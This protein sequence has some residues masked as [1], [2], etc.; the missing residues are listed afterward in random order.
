[1]IARIFFTT[2]ACCLLATF[3]SVAKTLELKFN[4]DGKFKIVQFTD[5]H[6]KYGNFASD[7]AIERINQVLDEERPDLV[8]FTGDIIYAAPADKGM[9]QILQLVANRKLPFIV[10]F[11]NHDDEFGMNRHQLY[12]L[13]RTISGNL[14]TDQ[15]TADN[16]DVA[17]HIKSSNSK[18][19]AAV[20]YCMDSRTY[21]TLKDVKGY[22]WFSFDQIEW[23]R[24]QSAS[25]TATNNETPLPALAFFHIPLPEFNLAATDENAVMIGTRMEQA[26]APVVNTGMFA[27]MKEC[28]D[29]MGVFVG[30][31]HD[32]DYAVMWQ[33]IL[34]GYGRYTGG[35]TVYNNLSNGARVIVLN[36]GERTFSS[37]IR[38]NDGVVNNITYPDSFVRA[39]H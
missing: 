28:G 3:C 36:E 24:K 29:V 15:T 20:I 5:V 7:I 17:L 18:Q 16:P 22:G 9:I 37:W 27:A 1:M 8:V 4:K 2:L 32:N 12:E 34:L 33:N 26:C 25:Y 19:D 6:C 11:G 23:Y 13:V 39:K 31:D 30:H 10:T 14:F 35:D 21:S 38:L